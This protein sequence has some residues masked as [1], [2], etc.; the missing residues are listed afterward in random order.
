MVMIRD[1]RDVNHPSWRKAKIV[2]VLGSREYNCEMDN[3]RIIK[4]HLDQIISFTERDEVFGE[5]SRHE[6]KVAETN[7]SAIDGTSNSNNVQIDAN[8]VDNK[9]SSRPKR[10]IKPPQRFVP[11][12]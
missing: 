5:V 8:I 3:G 9:K 12:N 7:H 6:D 4:R 2:E 10:N 11:G 1:Y